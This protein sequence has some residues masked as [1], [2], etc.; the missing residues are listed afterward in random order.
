MRPSCKQRGPA[1]LFD[2]KNMD[3][4]NDK[5]PLNFL[6]DDFI[7][8]AINIFLQEAGLLAAPDE[9]KGD[10][11]EKVVADLVDKANNLIIN[12]LS[13]EQLPKA[14]EIASSELDYAAREKALTEMLPA[15]PEEMRTLMDLILRKVRL[16]E[17][18]N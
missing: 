6:S 10:F 2:F 17:Y 3:Q 12:G 11:V 18:S 5:Q 15:F 1:C 13:E 14:L 8:A 9:E 4:A 16:G 7:F